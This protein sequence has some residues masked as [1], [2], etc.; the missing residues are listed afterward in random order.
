MI[1]LIVPVV[2]LQAQGVPPG[3]PTGLLVNHTVNPLHLD[4]N[5]PFFTWQ[6]ND[7]DRG[8]IQTAWQIVAGVSSQKLGIPP[9][10][11][12]DSGEVRSSRSVAVR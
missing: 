5:V 1:T 4:S 2:C 10:P 9:A 3:Q 12:W 7:V 8:E 6:V 11:V